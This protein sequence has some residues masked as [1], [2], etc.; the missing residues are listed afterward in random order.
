M[1]TVGL[2]PWAKSVVLHRIIGAMAS[3]GSTYKAQER[4]HKTEEL[5]M[6]KNENI[7]SSEEL[8]NEIKSEN[9]VKE[10]IEQ[11]IEN[12]FC[13][14]C[15][16][17]V[18]ECELATS[19][20][21]SEFENNEV[22]EETTDE[23]FVECN[24]EDFQEIENDKVANDISNDRNSFCCCEAYLNYLNNNTE[25]TDNISM[26]ISPRSG[27]FVVGSSVRLSSNAVWY[28]TSTTIPQFARERTS[29]IMEINGNRVVIT[30]QGAVVGAVRLQNLILISS[31][32]GGSTTPPSGGGTIIVGSSV[33]L[34]SNAVWYGTSSSIPQFVRERTSQV[35]E[36]IGNR[37]VI[38]YQGAVVGAVRLQ[39][40]ILIS[41]GGG[42]TTPPSGGGT[43][44]V[45]SSVR[46]SSN[47][48]WYG[49]TTIIPQFVRERTSQVMEIIG[50]RVVITYQGAV[51]GAVRLQDLILISGGGGGST[52]PPSGGGTI[53]VGSSVRL[54]SNAV[55]YGT[56]SSVPQF[57]RD[58]TSQVMEIIGNR[59]VITYQGGI[60]GA[61]RLQD[62][63]LISGG[64]GGSIT[65]PSGGGNSSTV[66]NRIG[67]ALGSGPNDR[68]LS[69]ITQIVIHHSANPTN[70]MHL[71]T[72]VFEN[73][74]RGNAGMGFPSD[75]RGGYHE[76]VL[77]NGHVE[78]NMQDARR[79]W[80]AAGQ[81]G[82]T[83][84]IAVTG[85]H[86]GGINNISNAQLGTLA[87]RIAAAMRRF[88]WN[89]NHVNRIVRH[90]EVQ[91]Q[92]T[93]CNDID[94]ANVRNS[95]RAL[96][97]TST[98]T[99]PP[100]AT[101][102]LNQTQQTALNNHIRSEIAILHNAIG[103][104]GSIPPVMIPGLVFD[105]REMRLP[106]LG[107]TCFTPTIERKL[108]VQNV[109]SDSPFESI[110]IQN[111][112]ITHEMTGLGN[113]VLNIFR[114]LNSYFDGIQLPTFQQQLPSAI[115]LP[116][117]T[118]S[119]I[120]DGRDPGIEIKARH[121][122]L[123]PGT[124]IP[125]AFESKLTLIPRGLPNNCDPAVNTTL[126]AEIQA[127]LDRAKDAVRRHAPSIVTGLIITAA[128]IVAVIAIKPTAL[129]AGALIIANEGTLSDAIATVK[130]SVLDAINSILIFWE[131]PVLN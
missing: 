89:A 121:S 84:H 33:R 17:G 87:V 104:G 101:M 100:I 58:R 9:V 78:V 109:I 128:I 15:S 120:F 42:S 3:F 88:G 20:L 43:I 29:Q 12:N 94:V 85:Q 35:M 64:G 13:S 63:I 10:F 48:V 69:A 82:H 61:V 70:G 114:R 112:R 116:N 75:N 28:G 118:I 18:L 91:G 56:S 93:A 44:V 45:G 83:W 38:T 11:D 122:I 129:G 127:Q 126:L 68:A 34:S 52:T 117:V 95:V 5:K 98:P 53:V 19:E 1:V 123:L 115:G 25:T 71:N 77:F 110:V 102:Q 8:G 37:V 62:L 108:V 72:S 57:A 119:L 60:V 96:L 106:T 66:T 14:C 131:L 54:S 36:I 81:N 27:N 97:S 99:S 32:G 90:R 31:G 39:D 23:K 4:A 124:Q 92:N 26:D 80:G 73:H 107:A 7:L 113:G 47:A 50:N 130:A 67:V 30:Y 22:S 2:S 86:S 125:L 24:C 65:P 49:T 74:W 55:W 40:L 59:V 105:R 41:G 111:G 76:V 79:T 51:V 21:Q 6:E 46:L 16:A 103:I